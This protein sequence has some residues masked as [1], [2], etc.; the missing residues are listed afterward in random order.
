M[1]QRSAAEL[2]L[3][4][5][6]MVC[7][8]LKAAFAVGGM[9]EFEVTQMPHV[10]GTPDKPFA[11]RVVP[12]GDLPAAKDTPQVCGKVRVTLWL[13][14]HTLS[15]VQRKPHVHTGRGLGQRNLKCHGVR[16]WTR[17]ALGQL[18]VLQLGT[19]GGIT[20]ITL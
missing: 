20:L 2:L 3:C 12:E 16:S 14:I 7:E 11:V 10:C 17:R 5:P 13:N 6:D 19:A 1:W 4:G 15:P 9:Y 18:R 8:R